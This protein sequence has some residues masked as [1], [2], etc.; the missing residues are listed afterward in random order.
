VALHGSKSFGIGIA[1]ALGFALP[2]LGMGLA[3]EAPPFGLPDSAPPSGLPDGAPPFG[4]PDSAP[5]VDV[6]D[7]GSGGTL[8]ATTAGAKPATIPPAVVVTDPGTS[9]SIDVSDPRSGEP[10]VS[11]SVV[12]GEGMPA[13]VSPGG[14][15]PDLPDLPIDDAEIAAAMATGGSG[16]GVYIPAGAALS[17]RAVPEPGSACLVGLGLVALARRRRRT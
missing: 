8:D 6:T 4:L 17:V 14:D 2:A 3:G 15:G 12:P 10:L 7:G 11:I 5:P 16:G 13:I 9:V 1:L